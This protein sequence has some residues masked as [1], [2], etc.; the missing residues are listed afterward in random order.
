MLFGFFD[1]LELQVYKVSIG[2]ACGLSWPPDRVVIQVLHEFTDPVIKVI[3]RQ[4][5][6][7]TNLPP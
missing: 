3:H 5:L 4:R 2:A 7:S 6:P 1:T